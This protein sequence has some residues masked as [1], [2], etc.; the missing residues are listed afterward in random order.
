MKFNP[1][2]KK[3]RNLI[4]CVATIII[5]VLKICSRPCTY[6]YTANF[7]TKTSRGLCCCH[8]GLPCRAVAPSPAGP[9]MHSALTSG[10]GI[11]VD[12][13]C[14]VTVIEL[15]M[16][17][18]ANESIRTEVANLKEGPNHGKLSSPNLHL[19]FNFPSPK[20]V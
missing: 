6:S 13:P 10:L 8:P 20:S 4:T 17:F 1:R 7:Q 16:P 18:V 19:K 2:M 15:I 12:F 5:M 9:A 14:V 11:P 3:P